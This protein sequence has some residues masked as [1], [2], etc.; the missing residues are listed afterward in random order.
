MAW[1]ACRVRS[2]EHNNG[3]TWEHPRC[4]LFPRLSTL[5]TFT[6][7][8]PRDWT[9][10][11]LTHDHTNKNPSFLMRCVGD[12]GKQSKESVRF[13]PL[14]QMTE[15][16]WFGVAAEVQNK[17]IAILTVSAAVFNFFPTFRRNFLGVAVSVSSWK[18]YKCQSHSIFL[19]RLHLRWFW[20]IKPHVCTFF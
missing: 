1:R 10:G 2:M 19:K 6:Y 11:A 15:E 4:H 5:Q 7:C 13:V 8:Q 3:I 20:C 12:E 17:N 9:G 16:V 14:C 18:V